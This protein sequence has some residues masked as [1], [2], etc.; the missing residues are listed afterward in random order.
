MVQ[1]EFGGEDTDL[2]A[3]KALIPRYKEYEA[4]AADALDY[5]IYM[6]GKGEVPKYREWV[7]AGTPDTWMAFVDIKQDPHLIELTASAQF[8]VSKNSPANRS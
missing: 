1:G 4:F 6:N 5:V 8:Y 3:F 2:S 7:D